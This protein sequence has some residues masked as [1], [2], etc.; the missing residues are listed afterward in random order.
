VSGYGWYDSSR[1]FFTYQEGLETQQNQAYCAVASAAAVINSFRGKLDLPVDKKY[2]PYPYATQDSLFNECTDENV[3]VHNSTF[4]GLLSSPG[5]LNLD[6]TK[7]LLE[8]NLPSEGWSVDAVHVDPSNVSIDDMRK[9]L[10]MALMSPASRVIVN[11]NRAAANQEGGGHFSPIGGYSHE[12]D[13]FLVMDVAKY[14]YPYVWIPAPVLY[15]SLMTVDACGSWKSP[16]A[17]VKLKESHPE[18]S[19]PESASDLARSL[20]KLGCK[21]AYRG[22]LLVSQL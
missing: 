14:K 11:F 3:T 18:L 17:Q 9:D 12:R 15:R 7:A 13:A 16:E 1:D 21:A 10:V 6:Q 8:C 5:G 4:D 2:K 19:E 22:Y 20:S